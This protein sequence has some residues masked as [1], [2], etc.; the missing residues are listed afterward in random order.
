MP[1]VIVAQCFGRYKAR[2]TSRHLPVRF[3]VGH[4]AIPASLL[5]VKDPDGAGYPAQFHNQGSHDLEEGLRGSSPIAAFC[6][7]ASTR[8]LKPLAENISARPRNSST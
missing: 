8:T 7:E 3:T 1:A 2:Q 5:K 4:S 6:S